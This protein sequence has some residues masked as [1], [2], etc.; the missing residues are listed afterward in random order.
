MRRVGLLAA[1]LAVLALPLPAAAVEEPFEL[2]IPVKLPQPPHP[3]VQWTLA[4]DVGGGLATREDDPRKLAGVFQMSVH[5]L[6]LFGRDKAEGLAG[7][8]CFDTGTWNGDS[9][10]TGMGAALLI[11]FG[12]YRPLVIEAWP[13]YLYYGKGSSFGYTVRLWWGLHAFNYLRSHVTTFGF[14]V[15]A[16]RSYGVREAE[17]WIIVIGAEMSLFVPF[18]PLIGLGSVALK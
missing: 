17:R 15:Q 8:L 9:F 11:P 12:G 13:Y 6:V 14:Y 4:L 18:L 16:S 1:A 7:G 3:K 10:V 2:P 5:S